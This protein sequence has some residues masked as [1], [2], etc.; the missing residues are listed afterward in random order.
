MSRKFISA[1]SAG[2]LL[3]ASPVAALCQAA[4]PPTA[5]AT[6][7]GDTDA[8]AYARKLVLA[9]RYMK[10]AR[11]DEI[12]TLSMKGMGASMIEQMEAQFPDMPKGYSKAVVEAMGESTAAMMKDMSDR[13]IPIIARVYTEDELTKISEFMES[14]VGQS[15]IDKTPQ[16]SAAMAQSMPQVMGDF[17]ADFQARL[18]RK[19]DCDA[20]ALKGFKPQKS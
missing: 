15:M 18:C 3:F 1:L 20:P 4:P 12:M 2:A 5:G 7:S 6:A 16:L 19:I 10:A 9:R 8:A 11:M 13:M 14:P 17:Q